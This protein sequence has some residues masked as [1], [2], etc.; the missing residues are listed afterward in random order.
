MAF[1]IVFPSF[2]V[3]FSRTTVYRQQAVATAYTAIGSSQL[4]PRLGVR[5]E[6]QVRVDQCRPSRADTPPGTPPTASCPP[7]RRIRVEASLR[8]SGPVRWV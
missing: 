3:V 5:C 4:G 7:L 6:A 1:A 2:L 8:D